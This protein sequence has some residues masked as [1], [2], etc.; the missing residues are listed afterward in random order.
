MHSVRNFVEK[1]C[2]MHCL[3]WLDRVV[4]IVP[5][6][7]LLWQVGKASAIESNGVQSK[8]LK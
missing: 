7:A 3:E 8:W 4:P 6:L 1:F 2:R 5:R